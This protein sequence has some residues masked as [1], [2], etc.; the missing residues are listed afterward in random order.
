MFDNVEFRHTTSSAIFRDL[1]GSRE[2]LLTSEVNFINIDFIDMVV[3]DTADN[4]L[5]VIIRTSA[6]LIRS[7]DKNRLQ[8]LKLKTNTLNTYQLALEYVEAY[9]DMHY[10]L[11]G[12]NTSENR[13]QARKLMLSGLACSNYKGSIE[14][15]RRDLINQYSRYIIT[16][17]FESNNVRS[18]ENIPLVNTW[19]VSLLG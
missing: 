17:L 18:Q 5:L 16:T 11:T 4:D 1:K 13:D 3:R 14:S 6:N 15:G 12:R 2:A 9:T 7:S 10:A 8:N 19:L